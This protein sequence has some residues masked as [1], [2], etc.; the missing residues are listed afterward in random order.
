MSFALALLEAR[1]NADGSAAKASFYMTSEYVAG[2]EAEDTAHVR[3]AWRAALAAGHEIGNHTHTHPHGEN[4]TIAKWTQEMETCSSWLEGPHVAVPRERIAGF[5]TPYAEYNDDALRAVQAFGF[6]YDCSIEEGFEEDQD[7]TNFYWPYTLD[8]GSPGHDVQVGW[9]LKHPLGA[10]PGLWEMPVY[11]VI[12][13]PDDEC[14]HY[15]VPVGLRAR[16]RRVQDYFD[17]ASGKITGADYNLWALFQMNKAEF[18]ATLKYTLDLRR[19]GNRAPF[20]LVV[21]ADIYASKYDV[22]MLASLADRQAALAELL[23]YA[24]SFPEVRVASAK[25][26]LDWIERPVGIR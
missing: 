16:L 25:Q 8:K 19:R 21:H 11:A 7:G 12:V 18:L 3:A 22:P 15:G 26:V 2:A 17:P 5:R 1:R 14:L 9:G 23:D 4:M 10:H 13:P 24:V 20:L 6:Q